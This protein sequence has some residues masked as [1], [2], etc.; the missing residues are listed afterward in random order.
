MKV[1]FSTN[2]DSILGTGVPIFHGKIVSNWALT[3]PQ[4]IE[5]LQE[6]LRRGVPVAGG[7]V[8]L[9]VDGSLSPT[10]DDWHCNRLRDESSEDYLIRSHRTSVNFIER[11]PEVKYPPLFAIVPAQC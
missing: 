3:R 6:L 5:A 11:Y 10:L 9:D 8:Y 4:A 7:D 1:V 2:V